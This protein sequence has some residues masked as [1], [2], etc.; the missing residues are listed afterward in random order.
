MKVITV[1]SLDGIPSQH[2]ADL[3]GV[4]RTSSN[5]QRLA[6]CLYLMSDLPDARHHLGDIEREYIKIFPPSLRHQF[7]PQDYADFQASAIR[8]LFNRETKDVREGFLTDRQR[9]WTSP[10][11]GHWRNTDLGNQVARQILRDNDRLVQKGEA[12]L[13]PVDEEL[14]QV[15]RPYMEEELAEEART[16]AV[17]EPE[18]APISENLLAHVDRILSSLPAIS[19]D[20]LPACNGPRVSASGGPKEV[21]GIIRGI[22]DLLPTSE[23]RLVISIDRNGY[24]VE[25]EA[26]CKGG[27]AGA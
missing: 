2:Q 8:F 11:R 27:G 3:Y 20:Q 5:G 21:S 24:R 23:A 19:F 12:V 25:I 1:D 9:L 4:M 7:S 18:A 22:T 14:P 10:Y 13:N 26:G 6:V 17:E 16:V 15:E